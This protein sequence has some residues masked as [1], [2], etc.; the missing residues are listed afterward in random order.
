MKCYRSLGKRT[1]ILLF[2]FLFSCQP[3][4][5]KWELEKTVT[6]RSNFNSGVLF[7]PAEECFTHLEFELAKTQSGVRAYINTFFS[8]IASTEDHQVEVSVATETDKYCFFA[9][10]LKGGQRLL[11]PDEAR[12][13]IIE[14]LLNDETIT[15]KVDRYQQRIPP[16]YFR[17]LYRELIHLK[18]G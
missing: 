7:F 10:I 16:T 11:L 14:L 13:M 9:D 2:L 1:I 3:L 17:K 8:P 5:P 15:I 4:R 12:D 18:S 6:R